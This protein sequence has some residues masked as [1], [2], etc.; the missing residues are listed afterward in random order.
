M[1]TLDP[2]A[3]HPGTS[4]R[5]FPFFDFCI[6]L[7]LAKHIRHAAQ[8]RA[9]A[10]HN[11][12][13]LIDSHV[14][15]HGGAPLLG[16]TALNSA[17]LVDTHALDAAQ[18]IEHD[19]ALHALVAS[20]GA[21][22]LGEAP[23][24][25][26]LIAHARQAEDDTAGDVFVEVDDAC[27]Q[28]CQLFLAVDEVGFVERGDCGFEDVI[29]EVVADGGLFFEAREQCAEDADDGYHGAGVA[30]TDCGVAEHEDWLEDG[31]GREE[32]VAHWGSA[33]VTLS[34]VF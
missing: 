29:A 20:V 25:A 7:R 9:R 24:D 14:L 34:M 4:L 13:C 8:I 3:R 10:A 32:E 22:Q 28:T 21:A 18:Q 11:S 23:V 12:R 17:L 16:R 2:F 33:V 6:V 1:R 31:G 26:V 27:N 15:F 30:D 19:G 5:H